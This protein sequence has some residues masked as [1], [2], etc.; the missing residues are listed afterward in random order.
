MLAITSRSHLLPSSRPWTTGISPGNERFLET[1]DQTTL[2]TILF[3]R[4]LFCH[5]ADQTTQPAERYGVRILA[6]RLFLHD[7]AP[8]RHLQPT[9]P[10]TPI[11]FN[12]TSLWML[13]ALLC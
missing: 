5:A 2:A 4:A 12:D 1:F 6:P 11:V 8:L 10:L 3:V 13:T 9:R 7:A